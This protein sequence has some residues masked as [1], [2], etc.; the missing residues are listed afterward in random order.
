[1]SGQSG[2]ARFLTPKPLLGEIHRGASRCS[3]LRILRI[4]YVIPSVGF[5]IR[6]TDMLRMQTAFPSIERWLGMAIMAIPGIPV[7]SPHVSSRKLARMARNSPKGLF[8]DQNSLLGVSECDAILLWPRAQ[9]CPFLQ[10][11]PVL[12]ETL[13]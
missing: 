3:V 4:L 11:I 8:Y 5:A 6:S 9:Y 12:L 10:N 7:C 1:M 2:S 13:F